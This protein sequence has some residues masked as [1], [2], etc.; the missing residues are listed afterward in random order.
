MK[1]VTV[2]PIEKVEDFRIYYERKQS[3]DDLAKTLAYENDMFEKN[4]SIFYEKLVKDNLECLR[5]LEN[6]WKNLQQ[7]YGIVLEK[8]EEMYIDFFSNELGIRKIFN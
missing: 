2:L 8:G 5:F 7:E 3:I 1:K 4:E 6:F